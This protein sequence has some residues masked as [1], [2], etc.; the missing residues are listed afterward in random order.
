MP[1]SILVR[2]IK[3][4]VFEKRVGGRRPLILDGFPRNLANMICWEDEVGD[5]IE[6]VCL[7]NF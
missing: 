5:E 2:L 7:L 3:R 4:H 6:L 1:S